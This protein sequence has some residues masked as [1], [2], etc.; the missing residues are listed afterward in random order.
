MISTLSAKP[1]IQTIVE[2]P[3]LLMG[4]IVRHIT[5]S[6]YLSCLLLLHFESFLAPTLLLLEIFLVLDVLFGLLE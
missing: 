1:M 2:I 6:T 3:Q 5:F 4:A